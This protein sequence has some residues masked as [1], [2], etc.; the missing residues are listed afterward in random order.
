VAIKVEPE[1][2]FTFEHAR[3]DEELKR[4]KLTVKIDTSNVNLN[5]LMGRIR[6]HVL[7][8]RIRVCK[9]QNK[10]KSMKDFLLGKRI[11]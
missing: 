10:I 9:K 1:E 7:I 5:D 3:L 8:N 4:Q 6:H 11:L 2:E